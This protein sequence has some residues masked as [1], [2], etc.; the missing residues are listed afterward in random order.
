MS[1][2]FVVARS[3]CEVTC[4]ATGKLQL[5]RFSISKNSHP[6]VA[7]PEW[8][9]NPSTPEPTP[10]ATFSAVIQVGIIRITRREFKFF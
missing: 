7:E 10:N 1:K 5:M 4:V 3:F 8:L 9:S 6:K 2:C